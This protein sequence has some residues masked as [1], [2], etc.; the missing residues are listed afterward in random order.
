MTIP[1][2][3]LVTPPMD[4]IQLIYASKATFVPSEPELRK[5]LD[6]SIQ[7]NTRDEIT[8]LLLFANGSFMQVLEGA[9]AAVLAT[10]ERI[11]KDGRHTEVTILSQ[12]KVAAREF[13]QWSMAFHVVDEADASQWPGYAPL[14]REGFDPAKIGAQPGLAFDILKT[15][16]TTI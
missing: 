16:A 12:S 5:L 14:F 13:G 15:L 6:A 8:G 7:N 9:E 2:G 4:L 11:K 1:V 10:M 3:R